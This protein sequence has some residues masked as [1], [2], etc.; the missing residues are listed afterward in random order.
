MVAADLVNKE[1]NEFTS[2]EIPESDQFNYKKLLVI[3]LWLSSRTLL[4]K[5][6]SKSFYKFEKDSNLSFKNKTVSAGQDISLVWCVLKQL[7]TYMSGKMFGY[8]QSG[9]AAW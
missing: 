5:A 8:L 7:S 4:S 1:E 6:R 9:W 3:C 2:N